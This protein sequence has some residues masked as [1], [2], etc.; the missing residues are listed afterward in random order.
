MLA[1]HTGSPVVT[2]GLIPRQCTIFYC[3]RIQNN[4]VHCNRGSLGIK[5]DCVKT[6]KD[7]EMVAICIVNSTLVFAKRPRRTLV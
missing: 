2:L 3:G 6:E 7:D 5:T 1:C 4:T